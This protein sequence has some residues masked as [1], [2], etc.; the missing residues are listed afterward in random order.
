VIVD[1]TIV[2]IRQRLLLAEP[3]AMAKHNS[4]APVEDKAREREVVFGAIKLGLK[5]GVDPEVV[6][7]VFTAQIEA[8]KVA[9]RSFLAQWSGRGPF[10]KAPNL[11]KEVRPQLDAI[12]PV[13]LDGLRR[14]RYWSDSELRF[15]LPRIYWQAWQIATKPLRK[16]LFRSR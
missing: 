11:A 7:K 5:K 3:V 9:Q 8:S 4:G 6:L 14:Q 1:G 12:T 16:P 2:V 15:R 13:I 10:A